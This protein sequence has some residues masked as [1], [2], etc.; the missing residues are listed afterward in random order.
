MVQEMIA[1]AAE[2][3][4]LAPDTWVPDGR[5]Q[6]K[7]YCF[8]F[9]GPQLL[10]AGRRI[11]AQLLD[12]KKFVRINNPWAVL[13]TAAKDRDL[14]YFPPECEL[15]ELEARP[16]VSRGPDALTNEP[17]RRPSA[18]AA[19]CGRNGRG[20]SPW[21]RL[22]LG[23]V[24][25]HTAGGIP[26]PRARRHKAGTKGNGGLRRVVHPPVPPSGHRRPLRSDRGLPGVSFPVALDVVGFVRPSPRR[27]P[28]GRSPTARL[29]SAGPS[30]SSREP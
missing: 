22:W 20:P 23:Q 25:R 6:L 12:P 11:A 9:S 5:P 7:Q 1:K 18:Q 30:A 15:A 21:W 4:G 10:H 24:P 13:A 14:S 3:A 17:P 26:A 8:K 29:P 16:P 19:Q 2:A 27:W 28:G